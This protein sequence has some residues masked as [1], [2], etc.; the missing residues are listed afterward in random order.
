MIGLSGKMPLEVRLV[1]GDVLDADAG[2]V[3]VDVAD[4][5][6]HQE[7]IAVRQRLT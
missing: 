5:V 2:F 3:A 7:R 1:D 6:D 4:P